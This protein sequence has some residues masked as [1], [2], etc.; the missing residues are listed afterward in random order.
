MKWIVAKMQELGV[1]N[2]PNYKLT[3]MMDSLAMITVHSPKYGVINVSSNENVIPYL[4]L[5]LPYCNDYFFLW[6]AESIK[7]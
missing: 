6:S 2:N 4:I 1:T 5:K 7:C 3:F